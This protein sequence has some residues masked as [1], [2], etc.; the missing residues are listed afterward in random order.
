MGGWGSSP[1]PPTVTQQIHEVKII[2][3][4]D[5]KNNFRDLPSGWHN[6]EQA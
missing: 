1:N 5:P 6:V 3:D 2:S 4:F